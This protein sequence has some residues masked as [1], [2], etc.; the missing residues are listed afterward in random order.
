M[1]INW[2]LIKY[3]LIC[4]MLWIKCGYCVCCVNE[5]ATNEYNDYVDMLLISILIWDRYRGDIVSMSIDGV[6]GSGWLVFV[7]KN[8]WMNGWMNESC[9]KCVSSVC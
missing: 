1:L 9:V 8:E 6:N 4:M 2:S 5:W 3:E 7:G